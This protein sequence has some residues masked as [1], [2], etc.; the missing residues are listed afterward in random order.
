MEAKK[1]HYEKLLEINPIAAGQFRR[2]QEKYAAAVADGDYEN[3]AKMDAEILNY[4]MMCTIDAQKYEENHGLTDK[5]IDERFA[6]RNAACSTF[7]QMF[8]TETDH[9]FEVLAELKSLAKWPCPKCSNCLKFDG[10]KQNWS[11]PA[12]RAKFES[13]FARPVF[14]D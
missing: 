14:Y 1:T 12:C 3:A 9:S 5:E 11:C 7:V 6:A 2:Q 10:Q 13:D 8:G 4:H